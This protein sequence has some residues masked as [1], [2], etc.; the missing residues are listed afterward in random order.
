[1]VFERIAL[2]GKPPRVELASNIQPK[3][4]NATDPSNR[5]AWHPHIAIIIDNVGL[6][7]A[8]Y[9]IDRI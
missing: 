9:F 5:H 8:V 2:H 6:A 4:I 3:P 1:M 7:L